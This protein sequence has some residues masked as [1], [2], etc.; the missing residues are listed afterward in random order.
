M[1]LMYKQH[2]TAQKN[3]MYQQHLTVQ[4]NLIYQRNQKHK[5]DQK[6]LMNLL[7]LMS[8]KNH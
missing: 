8:L 2:P 6:T 3:L 5:T 1:Y 7:Y 4:K